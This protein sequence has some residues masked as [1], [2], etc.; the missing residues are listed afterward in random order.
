MTTS[1]AD[2]GYG[3]VPTVL[4]VFQSPSWWVDTGANIHVCADISMFSSYQELQGVSVLM[5][6]GSHA[7]VRGVGKVDLKFTLRKIMQLRN[8]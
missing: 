1:N 7:S 3:N 5:G 6:N 2:D 8:V 4:S